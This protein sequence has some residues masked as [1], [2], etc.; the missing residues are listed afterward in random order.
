[1][2]KTWKAFA[3]DFDGTLVDS[4]SCLPAIYRSIAKQIGLP[5]E[6]IGRFVKKAIEYEDM[7]DYLGNYDRKTWWPDLFA[8]FD[9]KHEEEFLDKLLKKFWEMRA[10]KS[11]VIEGCT[12][13]LEVLKNKGFVLVII[14][15]NDGQKV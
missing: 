6:M 10:E 11:T 8:E 2:R 12:E 3:F 5:R 13:V 15:G 9:I 1:M 4:Y 14:A 7:H